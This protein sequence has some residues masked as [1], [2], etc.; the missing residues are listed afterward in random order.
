MSITGL[1]SLGYKDKVAGVDSKEQRD[2][3]TISGEVD[4]VYTNSARGNVTLHVNGKSASTSNLDIVIERHNIPD[5]G[6]WLLNS[7]V[8]IVYFTTADDLLN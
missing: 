8:K 1:Q 5:V 6:T 3:V 2:R 4:R 7:F